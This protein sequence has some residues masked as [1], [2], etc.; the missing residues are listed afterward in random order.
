MS[1]TGPK[2]PAATPAEPHSGLLAAETWVFDLDNTLY[3]ARCNLFDQVDRRMG[4]FIADALGL[5]H[6][7]ARV[8]QKQYFREYG[9]TLS[10]LMERHGVDPHDFL[11][12]VHDID[13]SPIERDARLSGALERL[14]ARKVIFTNGTVSHAEAVVERLGVGHHFEAIFDIA[15]ADFVPKP[16]PAPYRALVERHA[17]DPTRAVM[18]EDIAK[19]LETPAEMGMRTVWVRTDHAWSHPGVK[20]DGAEPEAYIHHVTDDLG[21]FL[22]ALFEAQAAEDGESR[23]AAAPEAG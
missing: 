12:F 8:V 18:V 4:A 1:S 17:I 11:H 2:P 15:A 22:H 7:E 16:R 6:E 5:T 19:N 3:P 20:D 23:G 9:T 13:Y 14:E 21:R 10:G